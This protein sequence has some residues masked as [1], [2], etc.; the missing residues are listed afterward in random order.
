[1]VSGDS[2]AAA[3]GGLGDQTRSS[4]TL[5]ISKANNKSG[6]RKVPF[7]P[8]LDA[9]AGGVIYFDREEVL[10]GV[11]DRSMFFVVPPFELD[12]L[13][14]ADPASINFGVDFYLDLCAKTFCRRIAP[15]NANAN[16]KSKI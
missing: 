8:R 2:T 11:Y 13:N 5:F 14:N 10:G 3:V 6:K 12:S 7:Y 16:P 15:L 4:G 9:S 1:M